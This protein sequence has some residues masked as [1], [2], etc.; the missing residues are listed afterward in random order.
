MKLASSLGGGVS[1]GLA[2]ALDGVVGANSLRDLGR[3]VVS[4]CS[5]SGG[6]LELRQSGSDSKRLGFEGFP[7]MKDSKVGGKLLEICWRGR[8]L[9]S[10]TRE[11]V[12][13]HQR[14]KG[15]EP[16]GALRLTPS[17]ACHL[18]MCPHL[19]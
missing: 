7:S 19:Y 5:G 3:A 12:P 1:G 10:C 6:V 18:K 16:I 9:V 8:R 13:G 4:L 14:T 17:D 11:L 15:S 2:Q